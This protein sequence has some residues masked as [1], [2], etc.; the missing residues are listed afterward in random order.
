MDRTGT[1][2]LTRARCFANRTTGLL[3][4]LLLVAPLALSA[5]VEAQGELGGRLALGFPMG[6]FA[7]NN[8]NIGP[9]LALHGAYVPVP[10]L[11]VGVGGTYMIFGEEKR[12][13]DIPLVD[14]DIQIQTNYNAA[15]FYLLAQLRG[16]V[17]RLTAY[18]EGRVGG[19]YLWTASKLVENDYFSD[20]DIG[21]ETN[22]DDFAFGY[23]LGG[24]FMFQVAE[25]RKASGDEDGG[26]PGIHLDL[27][28]FYMFGG[29]A[30]YLTEGDI[31]IDDQD[32]PVYDASQ[33]ATDMLH[34][35]LG[36][37]LSF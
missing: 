29:E 17:Q 27:K 34:I 13:I 12:D 31:T 14:D 10:Y 9:G 37:V 16:R 5:A 24:G 19:I 7:D 21:E 36:V 32:K 15:D 4:T 30:K 6:D 18:V 1:A 28:A 20:E 3:I 33:S 26:R 35:E 11:A 25:P 2:P 8:E 22:Y 23:G